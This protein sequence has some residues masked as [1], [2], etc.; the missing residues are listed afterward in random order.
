MNW[1][2]LI[3]APV[4]YLQRGFSP[5][6]STKLDEIIIPWEIGYFRNAGN[7]G[8]FIIQPDCLSTRRGW[9][10]GQ[11]MEGGVTVIDLYVKHF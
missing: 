5:E 4:L 3:G 7:C 10:E 9:R 6:P 1:N 8:V 2:V 11:I